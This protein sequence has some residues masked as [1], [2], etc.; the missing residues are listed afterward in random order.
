MTT[1][2][3]TDSD[4]DAPDQPVHDLRQ[5][6]LDAVAE[7]VGAAVRCVLDGDRLAARRVL[8]DGA[9]RHSLLLAAQD[10]ARRTIVGSTQRQRGV[11][12]LQLLGDVARINR[13]VDDL[14][15]T[16][17]AGA[18]GSDETGHPSQ[19]RREAMLLVG[20]FGEE[21]LHHLTDGPHA[22]LDHESA[23]CSRC[24]LE[25][26]DRLGAPTPFEHGQSPREV[27]VCAD[28]ATAVLQATRH[29]LR[30]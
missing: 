20:R 2:P 16:V 3:L 6:L 19:A 27:R 10:R 8:R 18:A 17:L 15:R 28:L 9:R 26:A 22:A 23:R 12:D 30:P 11:D 21:Q 29:A 4:A 25:A 14:A 24:L 5:V 1:S 13:L 7:A